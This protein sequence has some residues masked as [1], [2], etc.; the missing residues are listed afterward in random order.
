VLK[1]KP[2]GS[3]IADEAPM[4]R[5]QLEKHWIGQR[6]RGRSGAPSTK[7]AFSRRWKSTRAVESF[8]A[9]V[10]LC[11]WQ[12]VRRKKRPCGQDLTRGREGTKDELEA[13]KKRWRN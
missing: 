3:A 13:A 8:P 9:R 1:Q 10:R 12:L 11:K 7:S 5:C 6:K 4:G 2:H